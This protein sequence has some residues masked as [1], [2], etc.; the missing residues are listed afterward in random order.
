MGLPRKLKNFALFNNG[1][2]HVGEVP[3]VNLPKLSRKR[4]PAFHSSS[5]P[6]MPKSALIGPFMPPERQCSVLRAS[7]GKVTSSTSP[8]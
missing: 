7:F 1:V 2:A 5:R 8:R 6:S 4:P 3:E